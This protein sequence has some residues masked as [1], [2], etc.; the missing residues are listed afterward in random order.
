MEK[1][2]IKI[3]IEE[4][5]SS[6]DRNQI[7]SE[8]TKLLKSSDLK[9]VIS[10]II[11]KELKDNSELEK[12]TVQITKNVLTQ[13]FKALWTKKSVWVSSLSNKAS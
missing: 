2:I 4:G 1:N 9:D 3:R 8:V 12:Q 10:T 13:L 5:L 11:A 6:E 7:K